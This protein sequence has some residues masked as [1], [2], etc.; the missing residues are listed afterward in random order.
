MDQQIYTQLSEAKKTGQKKFAVLIDPDKVR[1]AKWQGVLENAVEAGVDY[2]F[3]GGSLVVND[4]LD[5]VLKSMKEKCNIPMILFPGNSFQLS[6]KADAILFLSLISGRN[7]DLL[8]GKH[9]ITAPFLKVSPLEIISTGYMLI[10]GGVLTSVQYMSNTNPI[11]NTKDDIAL[12]TAIAGEMLGLKLIYMDAGSGAKSPVSTSMIEAVSGG[13]S[14]P[15]IV[16]GGIKTPEKALENIKAGAD[17]I[18]VGN[19]IEKEPSLI[20]EMADAIHSYSHKNFVKV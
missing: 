12:C 7:A 3:I 8:I 17:V 4:M 19:A 11:P 9:V 16:G 5:Y 1:L 6:Y 13:I 18:V 14:I 20:L 2:F 15:L 10:D